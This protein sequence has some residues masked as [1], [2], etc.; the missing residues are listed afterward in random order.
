MN[1][2][3]TYIHTYIHDVNRELEDISTQLDIGDR[4]ETMARRQVFISL[5]DHKENFL[6]NPNCRLINPVKNNLELISKQILYRINNSIRSKTNAN[7]WRNTQSVIDW[8]SNIKD[9]DKHSFLVFDIVDF[10]PSISEALL[11]SS[12]EYAKQH[13]TISDEDVE[14]IMHL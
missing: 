10:Y 14:I 13:T 6:N 12:L 11:K 8:F 9:K 4:V 3:Y 7:Q 2:T 5:K 1:S